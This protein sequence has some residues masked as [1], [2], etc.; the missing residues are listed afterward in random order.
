MEPCSIL[1]TELMLQA[2]WV[3]ESSI[4]KVVA[5]LMSVYLRAPLR[6]LICSSK[7]SQL[8]G[9]AHQERMWEFHYWMKRKEESQ[10]ILHAFCLQLLELFATTETLFLSRHNIMIHGI[11]NLFIFLLL[12]A[13][14]SIGQWVMF[15]YHWLVK[16]LVCG[17]A[18]LLSGFF[19]QKFVV[20][21][22]DILFTEEERG[23]KRK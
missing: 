8:S 2:Y 13:G 19:V 1:R 18:V 17:A 21:W 4:Q 14:L 10:L 15:D 12:S 3:R 9:M 16:I 20:K 6:L 7:I 5:S 23:F 22:T 11:V